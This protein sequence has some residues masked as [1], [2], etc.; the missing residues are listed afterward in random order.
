MI[1]LMFKNDFLIFCFYI[2]IFNYIL[3]IE[4]ST[5]WFRIENWFSMQYVWSSKL[6]MYIY[7]YRAVG[8]LSKEVVV[9]SITPG[10]IFSFKYGPM[11]SSS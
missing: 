10:L 3:T 5:I 11:L 9:L 1:T 7:T 8:E 6:R 2:S 4:V